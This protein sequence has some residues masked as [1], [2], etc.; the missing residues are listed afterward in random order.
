MNLDELIK[1]GEVLRDS[2]K[3]DEWGIFMFLKGEGLEMWS[4]KCVIYMD[5]K[6]DNQFLY[7]KVKENAKDLN[8]GGYEKCLAI[9]GVL[10]AMKASISING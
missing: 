10:K 6:S 1:E 4:S 7:E 2:A 9:L 8:N 3:P 5:E